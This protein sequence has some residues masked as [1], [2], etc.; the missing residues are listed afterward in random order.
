M[1]NHS[2]FLAILIILVSGCVQQEEIK[3]ITIPGHGSQ[4]YQFSYDVRESIKVRSSGED[5]ISSLLRNA[6]RMSIIF[7]G[8]SREDNGYFSA[9]AFNIL[10][11]L[12]AFYAYEGK[13]LS[14][15]A[16]YYYDESGWHNKTGAAVEKPDLTDASIWLLG[17]HTGANGTSV[18][19]DGSVIYVQGT[20]LKNIAM[21]GDK[22][23]LIAM[24]IS[25]VEQ[26]KPA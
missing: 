5:A 14:D 13:L 12:Q 22:L 8:T 26:I 18:S 20:S 19:I 2:A 17:P 11:K 7:N 15:I 4:V 23:A 21:A 9:V 25:S 6:D 3:E 24:D 16:V 10:A 1:K